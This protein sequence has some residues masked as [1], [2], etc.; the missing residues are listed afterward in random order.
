MPTVDVLSFKCIIEEEDSPSILDRYIGSWGS[1]E[2]YVELE[3]RNGDKLL[4]DVF[5]GVDEG[6]RIFPDI[7]PFGFSIDGFVI[8]RLWEDDGDWRKNQETDHPEDADDLIGR[9]RVTVEDAVENGGR[10]TV[11]FSG[12]NGM[13]NLVYQVIA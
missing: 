8:I 4:S 5:R 7:K 11:T 1:D 12:E 10:H 2:V 3:R 13:Y 6:E 9:V